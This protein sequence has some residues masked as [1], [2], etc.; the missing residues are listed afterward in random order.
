MA[1]ASKL[2]FKASLAE[3]GD[4][5][6]LSVSGVSIVINNAY[7]R[8]LPKIIPEV[9]HGMDRAKKVKF[10]QKHR[11]AID[12]YFSYFFAEMKKD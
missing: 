9:F 7:I 3:I 10:V 8:M 2:L 5:M 1:H 12:E 11:I 6:G 4:K